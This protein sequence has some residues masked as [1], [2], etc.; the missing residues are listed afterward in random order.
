AGVALA[1][2]SEKESGIA[3]RSRGL[4]ISE[5]ARLIGIDARAEGA[6]EAVVL[7]GDGGICL[8]VSGKC[9]DLSQFEAVKVD[10]LRGGR[11]IDVP[12]NPRAFSKTWA[13][14]AGVENKLGPVR[15]ELPGSV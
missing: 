14:L 12:Y 6:T 15:I 11:F 10:H 13:M 9:R 2:A 5:P 4:S 8:T 1:R 3:L 7:N